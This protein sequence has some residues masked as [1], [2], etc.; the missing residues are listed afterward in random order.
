MELRSNDS[1]F[2]LLESA[3]RSTFHL[4]VRDTY[5]E[6]EE[7]EPLRRFLAGEPEPQNGYDKSDWVELVETLTGRGVTMGRVRIVTEPHSDYQRWLLS[8]T[9]SSVAAGEDIRYVARH[10]AGE[11]P[12]DDWWLFDDERVAFNVVDAD[13]KPAGAAI[14]TDP[15]LVAYCR[16]VRQRLWELAVPFG[17][18][19]APVA[20]RQ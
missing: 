7:S 17:E 11:L 19:V 12:L 16:G 8:V 6:P 5:L 13:G 2:E 15:G 20:P 14:T 1:W 10:L 18:Y 3:R 9:G 4:E